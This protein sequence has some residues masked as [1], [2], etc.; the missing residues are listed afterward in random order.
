MADRLR[1]ARLAA[2]YVRA[3]E[4]IRAFG[5]NKSTYYCHENAS[6]GITRD[7]II[8]YANA[9]HVARDWLASG[10]GPMRGSGPRRIIIEGHVGDLVEENN[11]QRQQVVEEIDLPSINP[12]ELS[13]WRVDGNRYYPEWRDQDVILILRNHGPP[14]DYLGKR[15]LIRLRS[16]GER[17]IGTLANGTRA[18]VFLLTLP[19]APAMSDV[20]I[21]EAAPIILTLLG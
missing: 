10:S 19:F 13:A 7:Q 3:V 6:R 4:A 5:W 14:E 21:L 2:G 15:C 8:V 1:R 16:T 17:L 12:D 9:F 20:E 18:G 11:R